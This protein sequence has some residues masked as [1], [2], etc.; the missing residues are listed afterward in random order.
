MQTSSNKPLP[1]WLAIGQLLLVIVILATGVIGFGLMPVLPLLTSILVLMLIARLQGH[2]VQTLQTALLNG[3]Q[4]GLAPIMIFILIGALIGVWMATNV[5]P[6]ILFVGLQIANPAWFLPAAVLVT[7]L[8]GSAIGSAFTTLATVGI[9]LMSIGITM[10][11]SPEIVAG[12]VLSGAIFGDKSSPLSDST[13]LAA[14]I[15]EVD[16][17]AHIK[18][19]MW[20]TLPALGLTLLAFVGINLQ[21]Q[22]HTEQTTQLTALQNALSPT[23]L[24]II[25]LGV[26][27]VLT[28]RKV[29]AIMT[30]FITLAVSS[31]L[32]LLQGNVQALSDIVFSGFQSTTTNETLATLLNRGGILAMMPTVVI[33]ILALGMGGLLTE[34][35]I[36]ERALAPLTQRLKRAQ[37]VVPATLAT[38]I[39][40]NIVIGEQYLATILPGQLFKNVFD[41]V[42]LARLSLSRTLEDGSTVM[43]YLVPWGVAGSFAAQTLGVSV[44]AFA[45]WT[46]FALLSPI[47]SVLSAWSGIG[48]KRQ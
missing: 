44:L 36:L 33:I 20:T 40:A 28:W 31:G 21:T 43:N 18:N 9:A 46:F 12:A 26:L 25:P 30:L 24:A 1:S 27:V 48:L 4:S 39:G 34:L 38:G 8:I 17:L 3:I 35:G 23:W 15:A 2:R 7:A 5:I 6:S 16:L 32:F 14:A 41:R 29:T 11:F 13:N 47:M 37:S 45:P 22:F 19:L 10:G 42:G